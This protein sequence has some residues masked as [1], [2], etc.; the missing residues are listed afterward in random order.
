MI[1]N[2]CDIIL[3][4]NLKFQIRIEDFIN[5]LKK[6]PN[7]FAFFPQEQPLSPLS[8][9]KYLISLLFCFYR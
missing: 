2:S 4:P 8:L 7:T 1:C 9:Y 3:N 6:Y 5:F